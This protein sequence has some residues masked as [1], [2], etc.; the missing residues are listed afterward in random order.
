MNHNIL[1][2]EIN[3]NWEYKS[4]LQH[5]GREVIELLGDTEFPFDSPI[6]GMES[7][8]AIKDFRFLIR[9]LIPISPNMPIMIPI[10]IPVPNALSADEAFS[11]FDDISDQLSNTIREGM[12]KASLVAPQSPQLIVPN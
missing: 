5:D 4:Y 9:L 8:T 12:Q 6:R 2:K 1:K 3:M 7:L 11:K 10:F